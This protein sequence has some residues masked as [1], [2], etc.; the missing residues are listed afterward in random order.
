[1]GKFGDTRGGRDQARLEIHLT[2]V[3]EQVLKCTWRPSLYELED[4]LGGC[5][6]ASLVMHL[7]A[8]MKRDWRST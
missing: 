8:M 5:H 6:R 3:I 1:L 4:K 2:A 7:E